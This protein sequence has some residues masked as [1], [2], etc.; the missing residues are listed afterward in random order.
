M[1]DFKE[2]MGRGQE[3]QHLAKGKGLG[4]KRED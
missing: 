2:A 1:F 3:K 4:K